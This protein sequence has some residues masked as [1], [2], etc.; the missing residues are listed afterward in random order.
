MCTHTETP[1][2][3]SDAP[4]APGQG[5]CS[6]NLAPVSV[7]SSGLSNGCCYVMYYRLL[8]GRDIAASRERERKGVGLRKTT[9]QHSRHTDQQPVE[10]TQHYTVTLGRVTPTACAIA[11][12][13]QRLLVSV[14][15]HQE[16]LSCPRTPCPDLILLWFL[17]LRHLP[18]PGWCPPTL[19]AL[20]H[21]LAIR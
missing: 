10:P 4:W 7:D 13:L 2:E 1:G 14:R 21:A 6:C 3:V 17:V 11:F 5:L 20:K 9:I 18:R 12:S 15:G 8:P 19:V 16:L